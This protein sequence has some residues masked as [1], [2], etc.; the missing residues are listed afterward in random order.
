[1]RVQTDDSV[2]IGGFIVTGNVPKQ[3]LIRGIGPSL[4]VPDA[5]ADPM[6]EVHGP[7][8]FAA[9]TNDNW[10]DTN[11]SAIQVTGI[12][13][14][15]DLE[16]AIFATLDPGAYT[17]IITGKG[18]TSGVALVEVYDLS[19]EASS[20]LANIS[21]RAFVG[22]GDNIVIAGFVLGEGGV[23]DKI[24][25]RGMGPSLA[26]AG[27]PNALADPS[28]ELRDLNGALILANND[29]RDNPVSADEITA[30]GLA[31][32][33]NLECAIA[34]ALP[35]GAYT[36]LLSGWDSGTGIGV[37]EVYARDGTASAAG[38]DSSLTKTR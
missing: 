29:W 32:T 16:P 17:A 35:A 5:L 24:V 3:L 36:A 9:I 1:M 12:P 37:I 14:P 4:G 15:N 30:A 22:T 21:T 7:G 18:N 8:A 6:L 10:R 23:D 28:L 26:A 34:V 27:V 11:A 13:P 33:S 31:P 20:K 25:V 2:G 38:R 19:Q